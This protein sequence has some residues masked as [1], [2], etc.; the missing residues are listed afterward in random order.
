MRLDSAE[1]LKP[2][3][4]LQVVNQIDF[5]SGVCAVIWNYWEQMHPERVVFDFLVHGDIDPKLAEIIRRRGC[6]I[7]QMPSLKLR[8]LI[9]YQKALRCFFRCHKEY[10]IVHGNL[11]NAAVFY[12]RE[13]KKAGVPVRIVHAHLAKGVHRT[14]KDLRNFVLGRIGMYDANVYFA[15]SKKAAV[16]AYGR[17][18]RD[19]HLIKNAI[20]TDKFRFDQKQRELYREKIGA[21]DALVLGHVGRFSAEKNHMYLLKILYAAKKQGI[22]CKLL[23]VGDGKQR[24]QIVRKI[25]EMG[26]K[27]D[28]IFTGMVEQTQGWLQVMDV[29]AMPS[30]VEGLPL[31]GIE[32]QCSGLP[33]LFSDAV[34]REAKILDSTRFLPA[35]D[36]CVQEWVNAAV[37]LRGTRT[38]DAW[39]QVERCGY[40]I[41]K[42]AGRLEKFYIKQKCLKAKK[43][44]K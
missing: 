18:S 11:A 8:N 7:Y 20:D 26:L 27:D 9:V 28:V 35:V 14:V 31:A 17:K 36:A 43:G 1:K 34:T 24:R 22:A 44:E 29:F 21:G 13:A 37:R 32:A 23:L 25:A 40:S 19:C 30:F 39:R 4:V 3:R 10:Q 5:G 15:C 38:A 6:M 12:L 2:V 16:Y 42:E 41:K 33:C